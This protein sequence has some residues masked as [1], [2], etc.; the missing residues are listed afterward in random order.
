[1][2][3]V[4]PKSKDAKA[5][6]LLPTALLERI[7]DRPSQHTRLGS[8]DES[9]ADEE[10]DDFGEMEGLHGIEGGAIPAEILKMMKEKENE[11]RQERKGKQAETKKGPVTVKVI[12]DDAKMRKILPPP[13]NKKEQNTKHSWM[14]GRGQVRRKA[15]GPALGMRAF[16]K[17]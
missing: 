13:S 17:K 12:K 14:A 15:V 9:E 1:M 8:D 4:A 3:A 5:P 6:A 2:I 7:G 16:A 10:E 11:K